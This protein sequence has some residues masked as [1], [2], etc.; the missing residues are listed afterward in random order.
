MTNV[1]LENKRVSRQFFVIIWIEYALIYMTKNCFN[2]AMASIV[3]EDVLTK[4]QTG[5]ISAVFYI[6]YG[7]LQIVGGILADRYNPENLI[8]LGLISSGALNVLLFFFHDYITMLVLWAANG[9]A[10]FAIWPAIFKIISS[11]LA[12]SDR[13]GAVY[14]ITFASIGGLLL[15]YLTAAVI[16]R[17]EYNFLISGLVLLILAVLW[18]AEC[19]SVDSFMIADQTIQIDSSQMETKHMST[20]AV[21]GKSGFYILVIFYFLRTIVDQSV[22]AF[23][24]TMFT[25]L[26]SGVQ[27][28]H[29]NLLNI[30]IIGFTMLGS[31]YIRKLYPRVIRNE[32]VGMLVL[33]AFTLPFCLVLNFIGIIDLSISVIC[34]C[35]IACLLNGTAIMNSFQNM[36]YARFERSATAAGIINGAASIGIVVT[37]YGVAVVSDCYGWKAVMALWLSLMALCVLLLAVVIPIWKRFTNN[38]LKG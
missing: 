37:S 33:S 8:K 2:A 14:Y 9:F 13:K 4:S 34:I 19:H 11:Q 28:S 18:V 17:W 35:I 26:Y 23:S 38:Y 16:T 31:V 36:H 10:Q 25:E 1:H 27:P 24:P 22:K 29:A 21:F 30:I 15:S 5:L 7:P 3:Y 32:I 20:T 6:V 12:P